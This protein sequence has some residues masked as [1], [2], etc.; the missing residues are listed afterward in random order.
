MHESNTLTS[1]FIIYEAV[2]RLNATGWP[3]FSTGRHCYFL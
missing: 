2:D 3:I 1:Y